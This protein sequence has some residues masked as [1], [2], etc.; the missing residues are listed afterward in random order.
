MTFTSGPATSGLTTSGLATSGL[1]TSDL[2][3]SGPFS[4]RFER[5]QI[6]ILITS[7]KSIPVEKL[8]H[9]HHDCWTLK[10]KDTEKFLDGTLASF[11]SF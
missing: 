1:V 5:P 7:G 9:E 8:H 4:V 2:A 6:K 10:Q 3:T 11:G